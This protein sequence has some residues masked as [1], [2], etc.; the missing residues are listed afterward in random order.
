MINER[1]NMKKQWLIALLSS[2]CVALHAQQNIQDSQAVWKHTDSISVN[3][4]PH[5]DI[6]KALYGKIAGL[7][8]IQGKGESVD[9]YS[10]FSLHGHAPIVLV[11]GFIRDISNLTTDEIESVTVLKDAVASALYGVRGANGVISIKTKRGTNRGLRIAAKYQVGMNTQFRAPEFAD[12]YTYATSVNKALELDGLAGTGYQPAELEAFKSGNFPYMYPNVNWWNEVYNK[13]ATNHRLNV[14]FDGGNKRFRYYTVVDYMFDRGLMKNLSTDNRYNS[15]L[16]DTRLNVRANIDAELTRTTQLR[17]GILGKIAEDNHPNFGNFYNVLYNTPAAAFPIRHEDGVWG[18][19]SVYGDKNPYALIAATGNHRNTYA[20]LL[21]DAELTQRLD[22]VL[23]GLSAQFRVSFDDSGRMYDSTSK[24]YRYKELVPVIQ[25]GVIEGAEPIVYGKD[26]ETLDHGDG[27]MS[28]YARTMVQGKLNYEWARDAHTLNAALI[29][30]QQS[31]TANGRN[32]STKRQSAMAT[33]SYD[34]DNRYS[35]SGVLNYSGTSYLPDG[36]RF[37]P[38]PAVSVAW[39]V[40]NERFFQQV[41]LDELKVY[42]S[43]GLSGWDGGLQHELYLQNYGKGGSYYFGSNATGLEGMA[44]GSFPVEG[45]TLEKSRKATVGF[46]MGALQKRL[47]VNV[48]GFWEKRSNILTQ[49][50]VSGIFGLEVGQMNAGIQ[51][52]SGL[53][54]SVSWQDK[55]GDFHYGIGANFSYLNSEWVENNESFQPYDYLY[56]KGDKVGQC[57]GWEV[58]GFF[59]DQ[60]DIDNSLPQNFNA[61]GV[62]PG[63]VKYKDQN[64]DKVIDELDRVKL[65]GSTVPS[66]YWGLNMNCSYKN[67]EFWADFQGVTGRT[68]NI[69]ESPVYKPLVKNGNLSS[70]FLENEVS[71]TP[72][73]ADRATMPRLTT[74]ENNNN[75]RASSL[76]FRNG[77]FFKLRNLMVAYTFPKKITGFADLKVYLQGT[78]LFSIDQ[79]DFADP[80][81]ITPDYPTTRSYWM[82]LKLNF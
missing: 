31:F 66:G 20:T 58:I 2:A 4:S 26:S 69:L 75:Y 19:S 81:Q 47:N 36:D 59:K 11:D 45:L 61:A 53:D 13:A 41:K 76:W 50:N 79:V 17:L 12:A 80:E 39:N 27:L 21:A 7:H 49:S 33:L 74:L 55:L 72:E 73:D 44:E 8:V 70:Y 62:R 1:M 38:Y 32:R 54:L 60:A 23:K 51:K 63:D 35:V 16:T 28:V 3:R 48:E 30:D 82:G 29:Y 5:I 6:A 43:C 65:S 14:S 24:K 68:M 40:A 52:Y 15:K 9:N 42:A 37:H 77:S 46:V 57:Y 25:N 34:Y 67:F 71:W 78:N 22:A 10:S 64:N 18:G 56:H